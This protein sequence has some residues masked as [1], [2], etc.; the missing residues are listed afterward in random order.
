MVFIRRRL[1]GIRVHESKLAF[2]DEHLNRLFNSAKGISL[3]IKLSKTQIID[4]IYKVLNINNMVDDIHI[5]L[6]ITRGDKLLL[7][8]TQIL[9]L[10]Q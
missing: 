4:Q 3:N 7:I 8:K 6:I 5:R 1:G 10:G 9:M 2:I